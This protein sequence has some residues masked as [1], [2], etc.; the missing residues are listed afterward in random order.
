M[1]LS[2]DGTL[3][4]W[5]RNTDCELGVANCCGHV[6]PG[7][8]RCSNPVA[9]ADVGVPTFVGGQHG[10]GLLTR[11]TAINAALYHHSMAID[12][13]GRA[14][15]WG[16]NISGQL[17]DGS[18]GPFWVGS[19]PDW[20]LH[21]PSPSGLLEDTNAI[22]AG[23]THSVALKADGTLYAW[24]EDS[25]G[26]LGDGAPTVFEPIPVTVACTRGVIGLQSGGGLGH[27]IVRRDD[28]SRCATGANNMGQLGDGTNVPTSAYFCDTSFVGTTLLMG[29]SK[30]RLF[31]D[32]VAQA[33]SYRV[34]RGDR[35]GGLGFAYNHTCLTPAGVPACP[36]SPLPCP[37]EHLDVSLP[38]VSD[39]FYY[40]AAG[41]YASCTEDHL[42]RASDYTLRPKNAPCP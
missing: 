30:E 27:T 25:V 40:L 10:L 8:T 21:P 6:G 7:V 28:W 12:V 38:T 29:P 2:S 17:G 19:Y 1:A 33:T 34:Y 35:F 36:G 31:W 24:G 3:K 9:Q 18:S 11:I 22:A 32:P 39:L 20:V 5:G 4:S 23:A 41:R 15:T 13:N 26:Q 16:D 42:G 14:W 37:P